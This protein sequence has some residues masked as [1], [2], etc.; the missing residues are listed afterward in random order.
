MG[1]SYPRFLLSRSTQGK[2]KG[3]F[4]IHTL[5]PGFIAEPAFDD[6]RR[7]I[8]IE[9]IKVFENGTYY[10][11][12][13]LEIAKTEV[14]KWWRYSGIHDSADPRDRIVSKLSTL[15]FLSDE[16][17]PF[18]IE[19]AQETIRIL[20]PTKANKI[21]NLTTSYGIKHHLER[22]S[23]MFNPK[24]SSKYCGNDVIKE[25]FK[26]EGFD[27]KVDGQNE[28]YN[29]LEKEYKRVSKMAFQIVNNPN[30][31]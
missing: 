17:Q 31:V 9:V 6:A 22:L 25:A 20:F 21:Y 10:E 14:P 12:K 3:T 23:M 7:I 4:I 15:F 2:S 1:R 13:A 29:I 28:C 30:L 26:R 19:E 8:D 27:H 18:T 11:D 5:D 16:S 24:S